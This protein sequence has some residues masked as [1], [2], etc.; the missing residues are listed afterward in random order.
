MVSRVQN[1]DN[2][3]LQFIDKLIPS[4][5]IFELVFDDKIK[6]MATYKRPSQADSQKVVLGNY[7]A[8]DWQAAT[9]EDLPMVLSSC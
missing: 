5:I 8:T 4:P 9:R 7:Y 1:I 6:V 2:E 3:I